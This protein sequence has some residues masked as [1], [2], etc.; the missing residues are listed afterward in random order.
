VLA[1]AAG[2][3]GF[4]QA[5]ELRA[6]SLRLDLVVLAACRTAAGRA[7]AGDH[8]RSLAYSFVEAGARSV[9]AASWEVPDQST[10]ELMR[11]FYAALRDGHSRVEALRLAK[12]DRLERGEPPSAWAALV[13]VGDGDAGLR[14]G[15]RVEPEKPSRLLAAMVTGLGAALLAVAALVRARRPLPAA[16]S[17]V[18]AE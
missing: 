17:E 10:Y 4:L 15:W 2:E 5:R 3:D 13:L 8:V 16:D 1:P 6:M 18:T 12:L 11:A 7:R 14:E 9:V